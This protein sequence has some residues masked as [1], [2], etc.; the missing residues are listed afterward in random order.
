MV[1]YN[2]PFFPVSLGPMGSSP[3]YLS[4]ALHPSSVGAL[5]KSRCNSFRIRASSPSLSIVFLMY[6][7]V[8]N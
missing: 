5:W 8:K 1:L 4:L 6:F 2:P 3:K 7:L